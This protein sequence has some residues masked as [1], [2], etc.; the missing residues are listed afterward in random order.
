MP[1]L[2]YFSS[3]FNSLIDQLPNIIGGI[4]WFIGFLILARIVRGFVRR[5]LERQTDNTKPIAMLTQLSY[6]TVVLFGLVVALQRLGVNLTAVLAGLGIAGF[7]IGFALQDV[8][9]NFIAGLLILI[10]QPFRPGDVIEVSDYTGTVMEIDLRATQLKTPDGRLVLIPN[11]NVYVSPITNFTRSAS[12]RVEIITGVAHNNDPEKIRQVILDAVRDVPGRIDA[13][14]PEI[15]FQDIGGLTSNFTV[16]YWI[17]T[18]K[19]DP[20]QAKD[21]GVAAI[22]K[23][24]ESENIE[25]PPTTQA[26][27]VNS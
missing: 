13:P 2:E 15:H 10:Q 16:F 14:A 3:L 26:I 7:T 1:V 6:W 8:S 22:K 12:R 24:F 17:D 20:V 21:A 18:S 9:K 27:Y 23:A 4:L 25:M 11:G 19:T 5:S